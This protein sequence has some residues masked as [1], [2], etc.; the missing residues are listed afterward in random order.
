[1]TADIIVAILGVILGIV[2]IVGSIVPAMPGPPVSWL[3]MLVMYLRFREEVTSRELLIWLGVTIAVTV[4]D[5]IVPPRITKA[6]GGSKAAVWGSAIGMLLGM[7]LTP[8]GMI[9]GGL[10]GAFIAEL[11]WGSQNGLKS[12]GAAF[13]ALIGFVVG[14]GLKL[15][16]SVWMLVIIISSCKIR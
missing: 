1:M 2:G 4:I 13:G 14:T 15:A 8:V 10:L 5:Y 11:L 12:A 7:F 3:G 6:T 16:A 9:L